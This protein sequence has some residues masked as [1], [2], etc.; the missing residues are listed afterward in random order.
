MDSFAVLTGASIPPSVNGL[1]DKHKDTGGIL[2]LLGTLH[3]GEGQLGV[4]EP[5]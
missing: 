2:P 4:L 1:V 3:T 5:R